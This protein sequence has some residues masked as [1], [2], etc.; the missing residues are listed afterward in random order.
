MKIKITLDR[1]FDTSEDDHAEMFEGFTDKDEMI[2]YALS[3]FAEDIDNLVKYNEV[4]ES[5]RVEVFE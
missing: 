1:E 3:C 5:A 2:K 4:R